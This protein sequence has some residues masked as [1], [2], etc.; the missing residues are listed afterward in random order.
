M[1]LLPDTVPV[2]VTTPT[3]PKLIELPVTVPLML[4]V[5]FGDESMMLPLSA[6]DVCAH[7]SVKEPL[8]GPLYVPIQEPERS[9]VAGAWVAGAAVGVAVDAVDCVG[10]GVPP[11]DSPQPASTPAATTMLAT[12]SLV[13]LF[14]CVVLRSSQKGPG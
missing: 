6:P 10:V 5:R 13:P 2:Y 3:A 7:V 11:D 1:L 9:T 8:N 14:M 12:M 4:R